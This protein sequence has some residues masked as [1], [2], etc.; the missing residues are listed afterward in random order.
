[1]RRDIVNSAL[2]VLV[3]TLLFGVAYPLAATGIAQVILPGKADGSRVERDGE[4]V[5]SKLIGQDFRK[6]VL[7]RNGEPR[8]DAD[9]NPVL[10]PDP[11]YFQ[12]RPSVTGYNPS[13]T[14]FNNLG[15]NNKE[16]SQLFSD[17]LEAYIALERPYSAGLQASDVPVDAVTTTASGVDPHISEANAR[18]QARRIAAVHK[19]PLARVQELVEDHTDSRDLG[20]LGEP[21][22]N[23]L[24][25]NLA[26]DEEAA[27]R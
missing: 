21:G 5:G 25:L 16:L 13:V 14:Y 24:E 27:A 15:P 3:L 20:V 12:S 9:G 18:I 22:V 23:V 8:T 7:D 4:L 26:V 1:V 11:R 10:E 17:N 6:P 2:A 19:L